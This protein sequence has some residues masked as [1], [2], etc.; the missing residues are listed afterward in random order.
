M[1]LRSTD[2]QVPELLPLSSPLPLLLW[3]P[4]EV[5]PGGQGLVALKAWASM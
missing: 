5:A 3:E 4:E 2:Q 1:A